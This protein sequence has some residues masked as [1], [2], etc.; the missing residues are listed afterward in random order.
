MQDE[1]R[2]GIKLKALPKNIGE[3]KP[4]RVTPL[5][6]DPQLQ[7]ALRLQSNNQINE[8]ASNDEDD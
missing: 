8:T 6:T 7:M 5:S 1:I 2:Q 4:V 3:K